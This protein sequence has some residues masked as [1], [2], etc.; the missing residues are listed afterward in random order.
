MNA[1]QIAVSR[2]RDAAAAAADT[3]RWCRWRSSASSCRSNT[4]G[5]HTGTLPWPG[6]ISCR[7]PSTCVGPCVRR[8]RGSRPAVCC[9]QQLGGRPSARG[10]RSRSGGVLATLT[11]PRPVS[12][13]CVGYSVQTAWYPGAYSQRRALVSGRPAPLVSGR[14]RYPG[15]Q[16]SSYPGMR[17]GTRYPGR[18][19]G[20]VSG[21]G[22]VSADIRAC[23]LSG[24][25]RYPVIRPPG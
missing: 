4:H 12:K 5:S 18:E 3:G 15:I 8:A 24:R 19:P 23:S 17:N 16:F 11:K 14:S 6:S 10:A 20:S 21:H 25:A 22:K 13:S 7:L 2:S 1:D 9:G